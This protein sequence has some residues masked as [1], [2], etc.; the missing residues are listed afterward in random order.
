MLHEN[1]HVPCKNGQT[2]PR[3]SPRKIIVTTEIGSSGQVSNS[4]HLIDFHIN[5]FIHPAINAS[6]NKNEFSSFL[7]LADVIP[8]FKK[9]SKNSKQN[10][11]SIR[12]KT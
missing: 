9:G 5:C 8:V 6:I 12:L 3:I 1:I 2:N 7:T 4:D 11:Q 10:Y